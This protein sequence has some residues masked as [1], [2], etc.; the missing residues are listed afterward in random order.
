MAIARQSLKLL[1][2]NFRLPVKSLIATGDGGLTSLKA[3]QIEKKMFSTS[4]ILSKEQ[5]EDLQKNPFFDKYAEKIAKLQKKNP[6]EFLA[7]IEATAGKS[8]PAQA[9]DFSLPGPAK[10]SL[11]AQGG[12]EE[13]QK[14]QKS[15]DSIVKLELLSQKTSQEIE[16]I[17]CEHFSSRDCVSAVIPAQTYRTMQ[18]RFAEFNT[19]LFPLPRDQGYEFVVVQFLGHEAHFTT[20]INYQAHK[21]NAPE[22]LNMIHY[23]DLAESKGI[24]LMVGEYDKDVLTS[25]EARCLADQVELYYN[26]P[27]AGKLGLLEKFTRQ[28]T[29]FSHE[30][31][32]AEMNNITL[33]ESA[34]AKN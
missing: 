29:L 32:I 5:M 24:V 2:S 18:E 10:Q 7:R 31:L 25:T 9:K 12:S 15:L 34:E 27:S 17:W 22:C 11:E 6:E 4:K 30:D 8:Q 19:F 3:F 14:K 1:K 16:K 33:G 26:K 13:P 28:P 23:T 20:L 21:E